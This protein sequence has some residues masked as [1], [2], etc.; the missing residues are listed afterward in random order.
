[1][2]FIARPNTVNHGVTLQ[3]V[4]LAQQGM[5]LLMARVST[6]QFANNTLTAVFIYP[7]LRRVHLQQGAAL[8]HF[9]LFGLNQRGKQ[10]CDNEDLGLHP[11]LL[12]TA[13]SGLSLAAHWSLLLCRDAEDRKVTVVYGPR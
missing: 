10:D 6:N 1:M 3:K 11:L 13:L 8:M 5:C 7:A 12:A 2:L 9:R 4:F